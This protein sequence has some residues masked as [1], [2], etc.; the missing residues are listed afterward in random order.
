MSDEGDA[1][2]LSRKEVSGSFPSPVLMRSK[3][4]DLA[5]AINESEDLQVLPQAIAEA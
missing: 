5:H 3:G 2:E 4:T 1:L